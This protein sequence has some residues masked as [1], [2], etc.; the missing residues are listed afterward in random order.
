MSKGQKHITE[1]RPPTGGSGT[2]HTAEHRPL[3]GAPGDQ[4]YSSIRAGLLRD[5]R[6]FEDNEF[7]VNARAIRR[8][9]NASPYIRWR[10]PGEISSDPTFVVQNATRFDLDQGELGDCWFV[11]G[12]ACLAI[13]NEKLFDRCVPK[14]QSFDENY[15]GIFRFNFWYYGKWVEVVVD[16]RLPTRNGRLIFAHN[17][18]QPNEFWAA[19]LEKAYCKLHGSCYENID[20]G[21]IGNAL[22][23]FT[24]GISEY[25][26]LT[27]GRPA[28]LFHTMQHTM[29]MNSMMGCSINPKE[30]REEELPG[31]LY[32]GHAYSITKIVKTE[33]NRRE[34]ELLRLRNPWG[35]KEWTGAWGDSSREWN[36]VS[37]E[38]KRKIG[39]LPRDDG[40]FWMDYDDWLSR[41]EVLQFCHLSPDGLSDEVATD[42]GKH[43]WKGVTH[44]NEWIK[45]FSAG[46]CGNRPHEALL[47]TNPQ[48]AVTLTD[49][50]DID[51]DGKC[52][53][54]ISLMKRT[55]NLGLFDT[56]ISFF[57]Y[58]LRHGRR[59]LLN[60]DNYEKEALFLTQQAETYTNLR[61]TATQYR[62]KPG[63]YVIIPTTYEANK[64]GKFLLRVFT[65]KE[66]T[67]EEV[68][69][70]TDIT[71]PEEASDP[72]EDMFAR[73][74]GSDSTMDAEELKKTLNDIY[75]SETT[76]GFGT[77]AARCMINFGDR[78]KTGTIN[79][80]EFKKMVKELDA[81]KG[82][83]VRYDTNKS[84]SID[85]YELTKVFEAVGLKM[86]R[87]VMS[88]II[89]RYGGKKRRMIFE[90]F[91]LCCTRLVVL[92][93][94]F[95]A[96][97]DDGTTGKV[98]L[99]LEDWLATTLY[100]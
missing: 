5:G 87:E 70:E 39:L 88:S 93:G 3:T 18:E 81:W 29:N 60:G 55:E 98:K 35:R 100:Y 26:N 54:V 51:K 77:E 13:A 86:S 8:D 24:G 41:F 69:E 74:T 31:G 28:N 21:H 25:I 23:D 61:E 45:G 53:M 4:D 37:D 27:K 17:R 80:K 67:M 65:E 72:L 30:H 82:A 83:F 9:G 99:T 73:Y 36:S 47:W 94:E 42:M 84:G 44:Y 71:P 57:L 96:R 52:T 63:T 20:G 64:E 58:K 12:A 75:K 76:T 15:A 97:S 50:D 78:N 7:P 66:A 19:I 1:E 90:D 22:V 16:D 38:Q 79:L 62:L 43:G 32:G 11:A 91:M 59:V 95:I 68:D 89:R 34:V 48:V 33:I 46:G 40:E 92:Y 6:L 56:Y 14:D 10:R 2:H 49:E 85:T